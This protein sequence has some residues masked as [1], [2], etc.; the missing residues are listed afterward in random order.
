MEEEDAFYCL[1]SLV[2]EVLKGNYASDM[3][4]TQARFKCVVSPTASL[5]NGAI[6]FRSRLCPPSTPPNQVDTRIF[7]HLAE[8]EFPLVVR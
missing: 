5:S 1:C 2:E 8:A 7:H 6:R 4:A 3:M